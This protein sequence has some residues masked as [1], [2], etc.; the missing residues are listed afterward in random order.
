MAPTLPTEQVYSSRD[1]AGVTVGPSSKIFL[2][3]AHRVPVFSLLGAR[4]LLYA[5][6]DICLGCVR[7]PW[8]RYPFTR[9]FERA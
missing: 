5:L 6:I 2:V 9:I 3:L 7:Y 4:R 1:F 8:S